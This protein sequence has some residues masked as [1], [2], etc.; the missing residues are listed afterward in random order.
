MTGSIRFFSP[1]ETARRLGVSVKALRVYEA[2]G[3]VKPARTEAGWR[4]YGPEQMGRLHQVLALK[5]LGL[6]LRRIDELLA[7]RLADLDAVLAVQEQALSQRKAEAERGLALLSLVRARLRKGEALSADDLTQLTRETAMTAK[8]MTPQEFDAVFQPL[9]AKH[10]TPEE[11]TALAVREKAEGAQGHADWGAIITE[12]HVALARR[13]DPAAP[14]AMDLARRWM[15]LVKRY[16][17]GDPALNRKVYGMWQEA[18]EDPDFRDRSHVP[19]ELMAFI[20]EAYDRA[21]AAGMATYP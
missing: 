1:S 17:G 6:P 20:R 13:L 19:P 15:D 18:Y 3:L 16:T 2:E 14:E 9:E 12:G 11:R 10:F 8:P 4:A 5:R 7:G 21:I